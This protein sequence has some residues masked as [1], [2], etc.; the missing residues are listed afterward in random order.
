MQIKNQQWHRTI[1]HP[2]FSIPLFFDAVWIVWFRFT[3]TQ[4]NLQKCKKAKS[5]W[6]GFG[7]GADLSRE[8]NGGKWPKFAEKRA[9]SQVEDAGDVRRWSSPPAGRPC[10]NT[11]CPRCLATPPPAAPAAPRSPVREAAARVSRSG[12]ALGRIRETSWSRGLGSARGDIGDDG[13]LGDRPLSVAFDSQVSRMLVFCVVPTNALVLAIRSSNYHAA[14]K[15]HIIGCNVISD[16][17][18]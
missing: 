3:T 8:P 13:Q 5:Y 11:C 7:Q 15:K 12:S 16:L 10:G 14:K 1:L 6:F 9:P 2:L 18:E 4:H 17:T